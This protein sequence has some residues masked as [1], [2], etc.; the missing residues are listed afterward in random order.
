MELRV[1]G[2]NN[3]AKTL[4]SKIIEG[5]NEFLDIDFDSAELK[6]LVSEIASEALNKSRIFQS[7]DKAVD[8]VC[9][10]DRLKDNDECKDCER[11]DRRLVGQLIREIEYQE[12]R[13]SR[14]CKEDR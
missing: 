14:L 11:L 1:K 9:Q 6:D 5:L 2:L 4:V 7:I 13:R 3:E 12:D 8:R 10:L